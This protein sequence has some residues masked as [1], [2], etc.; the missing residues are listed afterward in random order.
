VEEFGKISPEAYTAQSYAA[1]QNAVQSAQAL[2]ESDAT[3]QAELNMAVAKIEAAK[4]ALRPADQASGAVAPLEVFARGEYVRQCETVTLHIRADGHI[5]GVVIYND[6]NDI[7]QVQ[8]RY[9]NDGA[10]GDIVLAQFVEERPGTRTYHVYTVDAD[11]VPS[12]DC[13]DCQVVC[14]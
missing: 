6:Q 8:V 12:V 2:T 9:P 10:G 1:Y 3:K 7:M 5:A 13:V 14:Y 11:G 4:A